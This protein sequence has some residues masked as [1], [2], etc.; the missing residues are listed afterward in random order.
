MAC[1]GIEVD[2]N[3]LTDIHVSYKSGINFIDWMNTTKD[4]NESADFLDSLIADKQNGK[5]IKGTIL[6]E[7]KDS[8]YDW[9]DSYFAL[10]EEADMKSGGREVVP[11]LIGPT[12]VFKSATV[13]ELCA[14]YNY[15]MVDF[16]VA[17]TSRL[18][19]SGLFQIGEVDGKKFSYSCPM[20]ELVTC[21]DGFRAFC[22]KAHEKV[23][24]ILKDGFIE[25]N[26]VSDGENSD[27]NQ[28]QLTSEQIVKLNKLLQNYEYYMK[29]PVLFF[30]EVTRC[31]D[32]GVNGVLVQLLNQKRF[33]DMTLNGC[34]FVAATNLNINND[35]A[36]AEHKDELDDMYDVQEEIDVAYANRFMPLLVRPKDVEGRWF[37]WAES[38]KEKNGKTVTSIHQVIL[39][40]LRGPGKNMVYNDQPVLD[41]IERGLSDNEKRSQTF[42]NYRTWDMLSDY[43]YSID[44]D[45]ELRFK[46]DSEAKR[47]YRRN[48]IVGLISEWAGN[49]FINFIRD[50]G[51]Y[52]YDSVHGKV[53]DDVGD[54]LSSTLSSGVPALLIGPSSLG[55]TSRV[56]AYMKDVER[57]TGL[58]PILIN[59]NLASCDTTDMMGYPIKQSLVEYSS[60]KDLEAMG[61][62]SVQRDLQDVMKGIQSNVDYGMTDSVT[63]RAPDMRMKERFKRALDEGREVILFFDEAN[64]VKNPTIMSALFE[65]ISD[66]RFCNVSFK[67]QKDKVKI[68]AACNMSYSDMDSI[69]DV[70]SDAYS[71][72]GSLDPALAARFSMFWKKGYDENDVK[73]WI[74]FME[75][76][77]KEGNIDSTLVDYF[78]TLS[79]DEAI[80][81]MARVEART[82]ESAEPS[83]RTFFQMSKDIKS[84]RGKASKDGYRKSLYNG[85]V[86]F[87]DMISQEYVKVFT[88]MDNQNLGDTY[89]IQE[90][91]D[92]LKK[93]TEYR[94]NWEASITGEK[95]DV[96]NGRVLSGEDIMD[97]LA[98]IVE[99]LEDKL[100]R[101]LTKDDVELCKTYY[102]TAMDLVSSIQR[103]DQRTSDKRKDWFAMYVGE[104]F[105]RSFVSYFNS[106]Y[107]TEMD[108]DITI[109]MLSD[110]SLINPF[111][112]KKRAELSKLSGNTDKMIDEMLDLMREFLAVHGTTLPSKNYAMFI[113]GIRNVLPVADNMSTLLIRSDKTVEDMFMKGE[114]EG[115]SWIKGIVSCYSA[116]ISDKD[117]EDMKAKM[118]SI[119]S[120]KS[121]GRRSRIL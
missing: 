27:S 86:I 119:K 20:E 108:E 65:C 46:E 93:V 22:R 10:P 113:D 58:K 29:T 98:K 57:R 99:F 100:Q 96:G 15:R 8:I 121:S 71:G 37:E 118:S 82:L 84:M 54:F 40:F 110:T 101:P 60:G 28:V 88:D 30:D 109:E 95:I 47:E 104:D 48:I 52:E 103:M 74:A 73:S 32:Q 56:H 25:D 120:S 17:F 80:R 5:N 1:N 111:L 31:K 38:T 97:T 61:L 75:D 62:G 4:I 72:A 7:S 13:K 107:G 116:N 24:K 112:R 41:A 105:A 51:Y 68:V 53:V 64:R 42:P 11:L 34:K 9:L 14:K 83:T 89:I 106:V 91:V 81:T 19:Y 26:K 6:G 33:N 90:V 67:A 102:S 85:K 69:E 16:R 35:P 78:K 49:E 59:V 2:T 39:D 12:A 36:H 92:F 23:S 87:D 114:E 76:Q 18:D 50:R 66:S 3:E 21:S 45:Y 55:K 44:E 79:I 77:K 43:M 115:D 117:I 70:E 63:L 94:D